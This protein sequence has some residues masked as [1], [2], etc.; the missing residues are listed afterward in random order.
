M[1]AKDSLSRHGGLQLGLGGRSQVQGQPPLHSE[2]EANLGYLRPCLKHAHTCM[3][4]GQRGGGGRGRTAWSVVCALQEQGPQFNSQNLSK[5]CSGWGWALVTPT[6]ET[7]NHWG[8][9]A[10]KSHLNGAADQ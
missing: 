6:P 9:L 1:G 7:E 5:N 10:S 8:S 2:V 3:N 4:I